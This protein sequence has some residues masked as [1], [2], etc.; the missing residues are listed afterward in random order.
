VAFNGKLGPAALDIAAL[1]VYEGGHTPAGAGSA[2][3]A[4]MKHVA[5]CAILTAALALL[6]GAAAAQAVAGPMVKLD[7]FVVCANVENREPVGEADT[8][9]AT[10][11]K[12]FAFVELKEVAADTEIA[13]VWFHDEREAGR[14]TLAVRQG[15]RWRTHAYKTLHN[16]TGAWRVEVLDAGGAK[17]GDASFTVE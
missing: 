13:V 6:A 4:T 8:F 16:R 9:P 7:R 11:E 3:E 15:A 5:R 2:E 10:T 17:L 14:T 1:L 12:V